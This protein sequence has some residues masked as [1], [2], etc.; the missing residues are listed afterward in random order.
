MNDVIS[1]ISIIVKYRKKT[2]NLYVIINKNPQIKFKDHN[3]T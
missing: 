3:K 2:N 1:K